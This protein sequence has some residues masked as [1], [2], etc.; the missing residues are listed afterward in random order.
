MAPDRGWMSGEVEA[1]SFRGVIPGRLSMLHW[2]AAHPCTYEQHKLD[3][4]GGQKGER[5]NSQK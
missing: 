3:G 5:E 2:V 4:G 1:V